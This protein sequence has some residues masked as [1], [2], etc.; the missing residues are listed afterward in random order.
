MVRV[1]K[2]EELDKAL[3]MRLESLRLRLLCIG[4]ALYIPLTFISI[5]SSRSGLSIPSLDQGFVLSSGTYYTFLGLSYLGALLLL[6]ILWYSRTLNRI[7]IGFV[8]IAPLGAIHLNRW[9]ALQHF[10]EVWLG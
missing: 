10:P 2:G 8:I 7:V 9:Y 3:F 4:Y 6:F 5:A 1:N